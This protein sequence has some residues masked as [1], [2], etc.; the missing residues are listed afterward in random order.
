[1]FFLWQ[2]ETQKIIDKVAD[3]V[4]QQIQFAIKA[5]VCRHRKWEVCLRASRYI[6]R[7]IWALQCVVKLI[8]N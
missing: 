8:R 7:R 4:T 1:M 6:E 3:D 2:L 5:G